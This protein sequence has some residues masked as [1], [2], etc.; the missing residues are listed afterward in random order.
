MT[1][2][3]V[4]AYNT[5]PS[6]R[7]A[8]ARMDE[9]TRALLFGDIRNLFLESGV[10]DMYGLCLLHKHFPID[11]SERLVEYGHTSTPWRKPDDGGD[12]KYGGAIAAR[13]WRSVEG[14]MIPYEFFYSDVAPSYN[15]AFAAKLSILLHELGVQETFGL[16]Y[17]GGHDSALSMEITEGR[18]NIMMPR[19]AIPDSEVIDALWIFGVDEDD[20]CN[21]GEVCFKTS[22]GHD[23]DHKCG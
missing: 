7:Q 18:A 6:L 13:S 20:R 11:D 9:K 22:S 4:V 21:C 14:I 19:G 23:R 16:R 1:S 3:D 2:K 12:T 10:N 8:A 17:L 5:L 15:T